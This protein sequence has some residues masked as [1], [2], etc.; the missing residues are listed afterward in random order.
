MNNTQALETGIDLYT[1][2]ARESSSV[3]ISE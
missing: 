2:V 1:K 3:V